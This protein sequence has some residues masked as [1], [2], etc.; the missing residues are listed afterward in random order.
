M[1]SQSLESVI[2]SSKHSSISSKIKANQKYFTENGSP[3]YVGKWGRVEQNGLKGP[4]YVRQ[5]SAKGFGGEIFE[6]PLDG[7][8]FYRNPMIGSG[9]WYERRS[10]EPGN[11]RISPEQ[12]YSG[13]IFQSAIDGRIYTTKPTIGSPRQ[14][15]T[16]KQP[17]SSGTVHQY[18]GQTHRSEQ[19]NDEYLS[20]KKNQRLWSERFGGPPHWE[21][22]S[23]FD[24]FGG[25]RRQ[26]YSFI[27]DISNSRRRRT[28]PS[29][30]Q[31]SKG[32]DE[33]LLRSRNNGETE[34]ETHFGLFT[35]NVYRIPQIPDQSLKWQRYDA[36]HR[37]TSKNFGGTGG[38]YGKSPLPKNPSDHYYERAAES[39]PLK[40]GE[41][42]CECLRGLFIR[43]P[44]KKTLWTSV[45]AK[46][47]A[48]PT[49][50]KR[51][52]NENLDYYRM[53]WGLSSEVTENIPKYE[54]TWELS[55]WKNP[56]SQCGDC[57]QYPQYLFADES[58]TQ[59]SFSEESDGIS[60]E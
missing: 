51:T 18:S 43:E 29:K 21:T 56:C 46:L 45:W 4:V 36:N 3:N 22:N 15:R 41:V 32:S 47:K 49:S 11:V 54:K 9:H 53:L 35:G 1:R 57:P 42:K 34:G 8:R 7:R 44:P 17:Y 23:G 19:R 50:I 27:G 37:N 30:R 13:E 48:I 10:N 20:S 58:G 16:S 25:R 38:V 40:E 5:S 59:E 12:R 39:Q 6:S 26:L 60:E 52:F 2:N 33:R 28:P 55:R 24:E 31:S 14:E